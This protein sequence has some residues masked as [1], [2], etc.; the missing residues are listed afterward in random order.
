MLSMLTH[1]RHEH[2]QPELLLVWS[3]RDREEM[4]LEQG[5]AEL[6][7]TLVSFHCHC[8]Y[9][10]EKGGQRLDFDMLKKLLPPLDDSTDVYLCCPE[11]MMRNTRSNLILPNYRR[12]S[13]HSGIFGFYASPGGGETF[14]EKISAAE[15]VRG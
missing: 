9:T 7:Q 6:E 8:L 3:M 14:S 4:F 10:R 2:T 11:K 15:V 1:L 5:L 13:I 12:S